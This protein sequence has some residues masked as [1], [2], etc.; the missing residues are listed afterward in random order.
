MQMKEERVI[1]VTPLLPFKI[2]KASELLNAL[3][4][5]D[6]PK[7]RA[8]S[9]SSPMSLFPRSHY[10]RS[11]SPHTSGEW[12]FKPNSQLQSSINFLR[13]LLFHQNHLF[14]GFPQSDTINFEELDSSQMEEIRT[15]YRSEYNCIP[16]FAPNDLI[17]AFKAYCQN[18]LW[19]L[20]HY[21]I[22][23]DPIL[24]ANNRCW[25]AYK[26]IN[27]LFASEILKIFSK[28]DLLLILDFQFLLLPQE[29]RK[30]HSQAFIALF[31]SSCF[32][33]SE[34][35]RCLPGKRF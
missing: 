33:S 16:I 31:I 32:P 21:V 34:I 7:N 29:F 11:P 12:S 3:Q 18:S 28:N 23:E 15:I 17:E 4:Q 1:I 13:P 6:R 20:F 9:P 5:R 25:A 2:E 19:S 22:W 14:V 35:F 26:K 24:S 27:S 30:I 10:S 8:S